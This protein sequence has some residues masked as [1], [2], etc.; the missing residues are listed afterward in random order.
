MRPQ[1]NAQATYGP[2]LAK[3]F[4]VALAQWIAQEFPH[5]GGPKVRDLFVAEVTRLVDRF[6]PPPERLRPGQTVWLAVDKRDWPHDHRTLAET[7]LIP[8]VLTLVAPE[9]I[10]ALVQG[11]NRTH[12]SQQV[13]VRLH[14]EADAQGG[15]LA[16]ADTALLLAYS[17]GRISEL[18]RTYETRTGEVV[19]RRGTVHDLGP[20]LTHKALIARKALRECKSTAQVAS[21]TCHTAESVDRYLLDLM[22]CYICLKRAHQSLEQAAFATGLSV[23]L[24][25]EYAALIDELGLTDDNLPELLRK[26]QP[27]ET[28]RREPQAN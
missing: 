5:L 23:R 27:V 2:L 6:Y 8:V 4:P 15:V 11:V 25:A 28:E 7:R 19:P 3:T 10:R 21:E 12:V 20:S 1:S 18:I 16:E 24:V 13:V 14:R 9:D 26:L 17:L 22:R